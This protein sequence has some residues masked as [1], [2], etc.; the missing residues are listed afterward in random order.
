MSSEAPKFVIAPEITETVM[1]EAD[2]YDET[3]EY[4]KLTMA[5]AREQHPILYGYL[6]Q[7]AKE[8]G[9]YWYSY[10]IASSLS[11]AVV[12]AHLKAIGATIEITPDDLSKHKAVADRTFNDPRWNDETWVLER[13]STR[14]GINANS[15][16]ALFLNIVD[17][18][19]PEFAGYIADLTPRIEEPLNRRHTLRGFYDGFMPFYTKWVRSAEQN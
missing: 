14:D 18:T 13:A 5:K 6:A 4:A 11:Y 2:S 3:L 8:Q 1:D 19:A 15:G 10:G 9:E 17:A 16:L 7:T 12:T